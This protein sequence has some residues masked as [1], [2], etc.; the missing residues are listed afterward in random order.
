MFTISKEFS[1]EC[2]HSIEGHPG[3]CKRLHGHTYRIRLTFQGEMLDPLGMLVDFGVIKRLI[4]EKYDHKDLNIYLENVNPTAEN[5]A[6]VIWEEITAYCCTLPNKP[7]CI[8]VEVWETPT[9]KVIYTPE[10]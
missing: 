1:L 5:F 7:R 3:E 9:S 4:T 6:K 2:A 8:A 10:G